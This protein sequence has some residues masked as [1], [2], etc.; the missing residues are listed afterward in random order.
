MAR[1]VFFANVAALRALLLALAAALAWVAPA[2]EAKA[3][4][5][6]CS[7]SSDCDQGQA[8]QNCM[9]HRAELAAGGGIR[10]CKLYLRSDGV[11]GDYSIVNSGGTNQ[12]GASA[13]YYFGRACP[14]R[15]AYVGTSAPYSTAAGYALSGSIT[16]TDGCTQTWF[17]NGDGTF[18]GLYSES[19]TTCSIDDF[20]EKCGL[21]G[22]GYFWNA[23][24]GVCQPPRPKCTAGQ[25][26]DALTGE[27]KDACPPGMV[28]DAMGVCSNPNNECPAGHVKAPS[29]ECLPGEGQC[30]A[31]EVRRPNGT[32][33]RDDDDDGRPDDDDDDPD[34]D[35]KESAS[36][37]DT[38][39]AP[40]SCNGSPIACMQVRIQW[41]IDC[42]TRR[43]RNISGGTCTT[44]PVCTGEKCDAM[45]YAQLLQQWRATCA[46]EK[47][48]AGGGTGGGNDGGAMDPVSSGGVLGDDLDPSSV[49]QGKGG[50]WDGEP[51]RI[52]FDEGGYGFGRSCP[53][54]P[55]VTVMGHTLAFD[56]AVFCD[57]MRLGGV[58]VMIMAYLAGLSI[59]VRSL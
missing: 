8:Y 38:C 57:W 43:N 39:D 20:R 45:E 58:F 28:M 21:L 48:A 4:K 24:A 7:S 59:V 26:R 34:N 49:R 32:C 46:L 31:G 42:N 12:W 37:G 16:C 15:P 25:T 3:G 17:N 55:T 6:G 23:Y 14:S 29:G 19:S 22:G 18:T 44:I 51:E 54:P 27:C 40:P 35:P 36:G 50:S 9:R 52:S 56:T 30:A 13:V 41:R 11:S 47:I 10:T 53:T 33:G 1:V 2:P 5:Y